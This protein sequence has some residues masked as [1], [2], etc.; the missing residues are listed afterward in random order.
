MKQ[1]NF[2]MIGLL[3]L[4]SL[5]AGSLFANIYCSDNVSE[6]GVFNYEF[7][8]KMQNM[9]IDGQKLFQYVLMERIKLWTLLFLLAFT[10]IGSVIYVMFILGFG[11]MMGLICSVMVMS[12]GFL[13]TIYFSFLCLISQ[14][15]YF[16]AVFVGMFAGIECRKQKKGGNRMI[17]L[18]FLSLVFLFFSAC[19]ETIFNL[20]F[21]KYFYKW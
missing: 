18:L 11:F 7:I 16:A 4:I 5:T 21:V 8:E 17:F 12:H 10:S 15:I 20:C 6:L 14:M 3:L 19:V 13:G 9:N 2:R 1:F